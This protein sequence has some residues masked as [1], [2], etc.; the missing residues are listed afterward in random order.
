MQIPDEIRKCVVFACYKN[1]AGMQL[2]GTAFLI[3]IP[4]E[5]TKIKFV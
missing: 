2:A 1:G 5:G 4:V 3:S